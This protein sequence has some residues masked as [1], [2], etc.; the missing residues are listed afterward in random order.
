[1]GFFEVGRVVKSRGLTGEVKVLLTTD[2]PERLNARKVLFVGK[3]EQEA[4]EIRVKSVTIAGKFAFYRFSEI[5]RQEDAEKMIGKTLF[6]SVQELPKLKGDAAYVHELVGLKVLAENDIEIGVLNDVL[7]LPSTDAYEIKLANGKKI[8]IPAI[9]E[10]IE[11][12]HLTN[13]FVKIRR[14]EEFL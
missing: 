7:K 3:N 12:V 9:E 4:A 8:L 14:Y 10:F 6:V 1:M 11:E 5:L 13:G 2:F